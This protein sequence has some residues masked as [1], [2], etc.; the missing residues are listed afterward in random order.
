MHNQRFVSL[1][2]F[3]LLL[4]GCAPASQE[5][6]LVSP[7]VFIRGITLANGTRYAATFVKPYD[8]AELRDIQ[9]EITIPS[10]VILTGMS[11]PRQ[12]QYT[13]VRENGSTRTLSWRVDQVA[14]GQ[15]LDAFSFTVASPL[16]EELEFSMVWHDGSG[17]EYVEHFAEIPP[18]LMATQGSAQVTI[19]QEGYLPV[20]DSGV[21][22][23]G[24]V[25]DPP[26][27]I[28]AK[29]LPAAANPPAVFGSIW[30]CSVLELSGVP[31]GAPVRVLSPLRRPVAPFTQLAMFRQS[32]NGAWSPAEGMGV[33]TA[34][35]LFVEYEHPGGVVALGGDPSLQPA[36]VP[37]AVV[38]DGTSNTLLIAEATTVP[39]TEIVPSTQDT[40]MPSAGAP[41]DAAQQ[42]SATPLAQDAV[43]GSGGSGVRPGG[44]RS[45]T[46]PP[47]PTQIF[48]TLAPFLTSTNTPSG[49]SDGSSNTI[50][51]GE[52]T[53]TPTQAFVTLAPFLT[54]TNTPSGIADGSS[55]TLLIGE[56]TH[57]PTQR[58]VTLA[59]FETAANPILISELTATPSPT[60]R[61]VTLAPFIEPT[62][63]QANITDGSSNTILIGESTP[64]LVR[65]VTAT[66][67]PRA[68]ASLT[69]TATSRA[70]HSVATVVAVNPTAFS[71]ILPPLG[72]GGVRVI[73][74]TGSSGV[75][76]CQA[77]GAACA[78]IRR[79]RK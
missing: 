58:F 66:P 77:G 24:R 54:S 16:V 62:A 59:P 4:A 79:I 6:G 2:F 37:L 33:V 23:M 53:Q 50:L 8:G 64:A 15:A 20:G 65:L 68:V 38:S 36:S 7:N 73:I 55:N 18:V 61:F 75:M 13:E 42:P 72:S 32:P 34:D 19:N 74:L 29:I 27:T 69:P 76:Q 52:V 10:E 56:V 48:V 67:S 11:V 12:S 1:I 60:L 22:L 39:P 30:W 70:T 63:T 71:A 43:S 35:G 40:L 78:V 26:L 31:E 46:P 28:E 14:A 9:V 17:S 57:T 47:S 21:Q 25:Q 49:I 45:P 3:L 41:T 51:I 5:M 44:Q